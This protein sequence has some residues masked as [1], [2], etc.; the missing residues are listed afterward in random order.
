MNDMLSHGQE[1]KATADGLQQA[2]EQGKTL[3]FEQIAEFQKLQLRQTETTIELMRVF[4]RLKAA[5]PHLETAERLNKASEYLTASDKL[6]AE[7][8]DLL[9]KTIEG[10]NETST[11]AIVDTTTSTTTALPTGGTD[12]SSATTVPLNQ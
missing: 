6:L 7:V 3:S 11:E 2:Q 9:Q 5:P 8:R 10:K 1:L 12:P 4:E